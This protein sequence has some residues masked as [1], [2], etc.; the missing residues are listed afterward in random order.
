MLVKSDIDVQQ[1]HPLGWFVEQK[2][3]LCCSFWYDQKA[4]AKMQL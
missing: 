1:T 3:E 4:H 2:V